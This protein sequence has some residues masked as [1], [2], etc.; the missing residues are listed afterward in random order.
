MAAS[1]V[2]A[3]EEVLLAR[4]TSGR[5]SLSASVRTARLISSFSGTA[6]TAKSAAAMTAMSVT[7]FR[8]ARTWGFSASVSFPFF[9]SLSRFLTMVSMPRWRKLSWTSR[10]MTL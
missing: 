8:R 7:G 5:R 9:T 10:K 4:M 3:M 6:S 1:V 2:M